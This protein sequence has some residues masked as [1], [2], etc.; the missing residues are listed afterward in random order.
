MKK[1]MISNL[2]EEKYRAKYILYCEF[3]GSEYS[4]N[5][6]DYFLYDDCE[7]DCCGEGLKL[8]RFVLR[9]EEDGLYGV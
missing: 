5:P 2:S 8:V 1:M 7:L 3:C 6:N 9:Y 4:S